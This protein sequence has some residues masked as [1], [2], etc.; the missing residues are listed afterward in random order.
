[1]R[2]ALRSAAAHP[3]SASCRSTPILSLIR[4]HSRSHGTGGTVRLPGY[5][6]AGYSSPHKRAPASFG[7]RRAPIR[8]A[9]AEMP[10]PVLGTDVLSNTTGAADHGASA[11]GPPPC[12]SLNA[13]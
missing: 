6:R 1:M 11:G 5:G 9:D 4:L 2:S 13:T 10:E 12:P 7:R 3:A 8:S